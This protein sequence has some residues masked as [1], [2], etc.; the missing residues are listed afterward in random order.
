MKIK[1]PE[2]IAFKTKFFS[3]LQVL[4]SESSKFD[5]PDEPE[6]FDISVNDC[7]VHPVFSKKPDEFK[8]QYDFTLCDT[9]I[10]TLSF[11]IFKDA[12]RIEMTLKNQQQIK[13]KL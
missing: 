8:V 3:M 4:E 7:V 10:R 12:G 11:S 1:N 9:K 5:L 2:W 6:N 13:E